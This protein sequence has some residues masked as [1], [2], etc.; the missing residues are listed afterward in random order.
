M[1]MNESKPSGF[2]I[3]SF[4]NSWEGGRVAWKTMDTAPKN[5]EHIIF[6]MPEGFGLFL[7][8][9]GSW[10]TYGGK[11]VDATNCKWCWPNEWWSK[12]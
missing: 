2:S 7:Y 3:E 6:L 12:T 8:R 9:G 11:I 1:Q 4:W 10:W 5:G